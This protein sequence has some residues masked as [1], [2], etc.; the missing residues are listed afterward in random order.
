MHRILRLESLVAAVLTAAAAMHFPAAGD[1]DDALRTPLPVLTVGRASGPITIDGTLNE[2]AWDRAARIPVLQDWRSGRPVRPETSIR[3]CWDHE[4]LFAAWECAEPHMDQIVAGTDS[5]VWQDDDVECFVQLPGRPDY[6][7]FMVNALGRLQYESSTGEPYAPRAHA[8][9]RRGPDGWTVEL[10]VPWTDIGGAPRPGEV[11]RA[12]F[13]RVRKPAPPAF[14]CWSVTGGSFHNP[15][16]FGTLRFAESAPVRIERLVPGELMLGVNRA[17]FAGI[18]R[19]ETEGAAAVLLGGKELATQA[20]RGGNPWRIRCAYTLDLDTAP[21]LVFQVQSGAGEVWY[22]RAFPL[23]ISGRDVL[24]ELRRA[25][26]RTQQRLQ[27]QNLPPPVRQALATA[28]KD[29]ETVLKR[30]RD[31]I[32][33]AVTEKRIVTPA[34]WAAIVS[35][36]RRAA[37]NLTRPLVWTRDPYEVTR[38]DDL[39]AEL[40]ENVELRIQAFRNEYETGALLISNV[41]SHRPLELRIRLGALEAIPENAP[42]GSEAP[43]LGPTRLELAEAV[44]VRTAGHGRRTDPIVPLDAAGRLFVPPGETRELWLTVNTFGA[45]PGLYRGTLRIESMDPL[46]DAWTIHTPVAVRIW[47]L[48]IAETCRIRVFN[49]DYYRGASSDAYLQDLLRHRVNVFALR[50]PRPDADGKADFSQLDEPIRRVRGHGMIFFESWFFRSKGWQ[51]Q[52][53]RWVRGLAAYMRAK[54]FTKKDWVLHIFDETLSDRFLD[55]ARRIKKIEP[56]LPLFSDRMGPPDRIEQFAPVVDYWCPHYKDLTKPGFAAMRRSGHPVWTYD[57]GS[58]KAVSP[59]HNRALPWCAWHYRLDGVCYWTYF[60]NYGDPWNDLDAGRRPDW[61]KVYVDRNGGPLSSKRWEAW[62]EGLEDFALFDLYAAALKRR[63]DLSPEDRKL[64]A[65]VHAVGAAA[66]APAA[67]IARIVDSVRRRVLALNG[68]R[69]PAF[70]P[71]CEIEWT[72]RT[73]GDGRG[74]I[75]RVTADS[76]AQR[77]QTGALLRSP[78]AHSWTFLVKA[79]TV[80]QGKKL[81]LEFRARGAGRLKAGF[82]EGFQWGGDGRGHR[83]T[84]RYLSL[85]DDW[86][87]LRIEHVVGAERPVEALIGFDYGNARAVAEIRDYRVEI[88]P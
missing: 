3:V 87:H 53:A 72:P 66:D 21:F 64:P 30:M 59:S 31:E 5:E 80:E 2:D 65:D 43:P 37:R 85:K 7:H 83:A 41:F 71:Y 77:R 79:L 42:D 34:S 55:T 15:A 45:R 49:F 75:R 84:I 35:A 19:P 54:G 6:R 47:P 18:G 29:V 74:R 9:A 56:D 88:T 36:A 44:M 61:S 73:A 38:P 78:T 24:E 23:S 11:R 70:P 48:A 26:R 58:G 33:K 22:R 82:C 4:F 52:H 25:D 81:V 67:D 1:G 32:R 16:R 17:E 63:A 68:I 69:T 14:G 62:R 27:Q 50:V 40:Q 86:Q 28:A 46:L 13:H 76:A 51:P 20:F 57:C 10:A 12:N 60:S 39:P 8:A